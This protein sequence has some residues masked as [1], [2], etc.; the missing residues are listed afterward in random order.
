M[1][2]RAAKQVLTFCNIVCRSGARSALCDPRSGVQA[3][4]AAGNSG[5]SPRVLEYNRPAQP[6]SPHQSWPQ[7][8]EAQQLHTWQNAGHDQRVRSQKRLVEDVRSK[9]EARRRGG[10]F[11]GPPAASLATPDRQQLPQP[12]HPAQRSQTVP[13]SAPT[14]R[15]QLT[16]HTFAAVA[17]PAAQPEQLASDEEQQWMQQQQ[18]RERVQSSAGTSTSGRQHQRQQLSGEIECFES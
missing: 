16:T 12:P 14:Q 5:D 6:F 2:Q 1:Q 9:D 3:V 10:N 13:S 18:L 15:H 4:A 11:N 17:Q 8:S 7:H